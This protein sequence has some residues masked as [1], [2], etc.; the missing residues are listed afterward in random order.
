MFDVGGCNS[1][2]APVLL[3]LISLVCHLGRPCSRIEVATVPAKMKMG[4]RNLI[5]TFGM[6][7]RTC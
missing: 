4:R 1:S 5:D 3:V 7:Y 6:L 2:S